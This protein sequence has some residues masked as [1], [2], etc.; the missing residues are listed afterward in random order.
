MSYN[1]RVVKITTS[2]HPNADRIQI[3]YCDGFQVIVGLET[4]DGELGVF[5]PSDGQL[6]EE[7]CQQNDLVGVFENGKRVSGGYF[8]KDR[9]VRLQK[10]RGVES[11][12]FYIPLSSLEYTG[13]DLSE[14]TEGST[15]DYLNGH[16]ICNKHFTKATDKIIGGQTN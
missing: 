14:L 12:G 7:F 11:E 16:P 6:S 1:A 8:S 9:R 3:G 4:K 15:F 5:F 2:P 13:A 10:M